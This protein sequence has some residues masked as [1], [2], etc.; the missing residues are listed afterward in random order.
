[1]NDGTAGVRISTPYRF[2]ISNLI[3]QGSNS[4]IIEVTNTL[5]KDQRDPFSLLAQQEPSGLLGPVR[6]LHSIIQG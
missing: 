6:I 4:L 3:E 1:M 2:N 5:V